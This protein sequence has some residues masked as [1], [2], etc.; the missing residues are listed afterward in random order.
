ME[1][2]IEREMAGYV[3]RRATEFTASGFIRS[4]CQKLTDGSDVISWLKSEME[5]I[6]ID[7]SEQEWS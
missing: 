3:I 4:L 6:P 5:R 1:Y 7:L 2:Q